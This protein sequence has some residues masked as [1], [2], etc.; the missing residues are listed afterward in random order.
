MLVSVVLSAPEAREHQQQQCLGKQSYRC[1]HAPQRKVKQSRQQVQQLAL[2]T[3]GAECRL[4][5]RL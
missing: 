2:G 4:V 1:R 5:S 3:L